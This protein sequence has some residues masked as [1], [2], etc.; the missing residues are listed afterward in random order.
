M[1]RRIA[2]VGASSSIG[3]R[4]YDDGEVRNLYRTPGVLRERGLIE[5]LDA[6]DLGDVVAPPYRDFV[7]PPGRARNEA[8]V[9][10][11]S[12]LLAE[13]VAVATSH[14]R[15][16]VVVGGDC[17][18]VLGCLLGAKRTAGGPVGL[19]Y[20]DGHADFA[21]PEE[22]R[23]GSV[24]SMAL[25]LASGRGDTPL[26][27][28]AGRTPLVDASHIALV[29]RRDAAEA[30]YGHSALAASSILDV[31]D[32]Q[33]MSRDPAAVAADVLA[34]VAAAGVERFWI[35]VDADVIHPAMMP[36]VDSPEPGGPMPDELVELLTPL[37]LHPR[38][39]GLS[40]TIYD[41]AL[42]SDR[43]GA[44]QLLRMLETLLKAE[45]RRQKSEVSQN[46]EVRGS[47]SAFPSTSDF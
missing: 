5:R 31:A 25:A 17:S 20:V 10:R 34:R 30:W 27:R 43:S 28:L 6:A 38:A 11:Y 12:R 45:G 15:F 21:T 9:I 39:I 47:G 41:P 16:A 13:R 18:I 7:R 35:Q 44:R 23:T 3:I 8:E 40:L 37:V 42:D 46:S 22:S 24:A 4:P 1:D 14:G 32:G 26:A 29:G 2:V 33:L 19:V 36:A